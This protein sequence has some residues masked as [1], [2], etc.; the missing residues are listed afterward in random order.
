MRMDCWKKAAD[1]RVLLVYPN[2]QRSEQMPYKIGLFTALLRQ[3]GFEVALFD[4]TFYLDDLIANYE[5]FRTYVRRYDWEERNVK[6][7]IGLLADFRRK[8]D[9]FQ[10]DLIAMS[11]VENTYEIG[12]T[13]IRS[14]PPRWQ[15]VP[16]L[17][18]GVFP[19]FAP[20]IIL[21]EN[22]GHFVCRGEGEIALLEFCRRM[23]AGEPLTDVPNIWANIDGTMHRNRSAPLVNLNDLPFPDYSLFEPQAIYRPM[24]GKIRRTVGIESQRGCPFPC[25]FCNSPS[26][27]AL[28]RADGGAAFNRRKSP[29][30]IRE[31]ID[32]LHKRHDIELIYWLADTFLALP[33]REFDELAEVYEDV[34]IAFW[35]NTRTET[36]T[37]YVA[38]RLERMNMLRMSFGIEHGNY[39]YR[40]VML[41]R[42]VTNSQMLRAFQ[43]CSGRSFTVSA[44]CIIGMPDETRDLIFETIE[45]TRQLPADF[46]HTGCFIF[47][48]YHGTELRRIAE[49]KGYIDPEAVGNM[50]DPTTSMIDQPHLP[51]H[52]VVGLAK[53]FGLYE[54]APKSA[55]Q[56]IRIAEQETA[57]GN[58]M[59]DQLQ[60]TYRAGDVGEPK[61][62]SPVGRPIQAEL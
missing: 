25:T 14:L 11:I 38:D 29:R 32:F 49:A 21:N 26:Q 57:E 17:W 42:N 2:I 8:V 55:W 24:Q 45:L 30:R 36:M 20:E 28:A 3:E 19:T 35:M 62:E 39:E 61:R 10:P 6:F 51:R 27:S 40:R 60:K 48:P 52:E 4:C 1:Y 56:N 22:P 5:H 33:P 59:L 58:A 47:A 46:E 23:C 7:T 50:T 34:R 31:E 54:V 41:K 12:R 37:E 18:G 16:I 43:I 44:N 53:T 9:A 13:M 15:H